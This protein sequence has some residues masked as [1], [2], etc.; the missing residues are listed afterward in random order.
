MIAKY[1]LPHLIGLVCI[2]SGWYVAIINVGL[3]KFNQERS[4]HTKETLAGLVLIIIGAYI[5]HIWIGI[6]NMFSKKKD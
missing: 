1:I 3:F 6:G 5:P 2:V 4:L